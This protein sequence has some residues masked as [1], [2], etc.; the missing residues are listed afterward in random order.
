MAGIHTEKLGKTMGNMAEIWEIWGKYGIY[1]SSS[2]SWV[3][4]Q[5]ARHEQLTLEAK[6]RRFG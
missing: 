4:F 3:I 1:K 6:G 5:H 2:F